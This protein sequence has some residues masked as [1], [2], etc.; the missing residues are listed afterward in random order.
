[1]YNQYRNVGWGGVS[2]DPNNPN[3]RTDQ[4]LLS[5][6]ALYNYENPQASFDNALRYQGYNPNAANPYMQSLRSMAPAMSNSFLSSMAQNPNATADRTQNTGELYRNY[7]GAVMGGN[8]PAGQSS[9][10][11]T[12][13]DSATGMR[14]AI[15]AARNFNPTNVQ[16]INP[17]LGALQERMAADQ[18]HGAL[19]M[20]QS[21]YSPMMGRATRSAY[22]NALDTAYGNAQ[23]QFG[24]RP[25]TNLQGLLSGDIY[26]YLFGF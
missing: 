24:T 23:Y 17:F 13:N 12:L 14:D 22:G 19:D 8:G 5:N 10:Y 20:L 9:V 26:Q 4:N 15:T 3:Y 18:G 25:T 7:L 1:M 11:A 21:F 16:Q 6:N 2:T